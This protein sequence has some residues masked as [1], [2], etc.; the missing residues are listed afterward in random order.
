MVDTSEA[1]TVAWGV[2]GVF[3]VSG[4]LD[5][6]G[7]EVMTG[8]GESVDEYGATGAGFFESHEPF[9]VFTVFGRREY[10]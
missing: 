1:A 3:S 6:D 9:Q 8:G 7:A 10:G 2:F 4:V 5:W